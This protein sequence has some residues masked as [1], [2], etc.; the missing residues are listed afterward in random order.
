M[1]NPPLGTA[2]GEEG[3][4]HRRNDVPEG[5]ISQKT[6]PHLSTGACV[7]SDF[8][9]STC[10]EQEYPTTWKVV[11]TKGE[12]IFRTLRSFVMQVSQDQQQMSSATNLN[13]INHTL[14]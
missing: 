8:L 10:R 7:Q 11:C 13:Q 14:S 4:K 3:K 1:E 2:M 9:L 12:G 5:H 6:F